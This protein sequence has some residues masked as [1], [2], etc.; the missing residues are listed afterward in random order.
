MI[1]VGKKYRVYVY[2]THGKD[3][4]AFEGTIKD[5]DDKGILLEVENEIIIDKEPK[6]MTK[7]YYIPFT[8]IEMIEFLDASSVLE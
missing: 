8:S 7:I 4:V 3:L 6:K 2:A 5:K 1:Y